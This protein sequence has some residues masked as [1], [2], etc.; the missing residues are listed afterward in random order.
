MAQQ[1]YYWNLRSKQIGIQ[2]KVTGVQ[3][4]EAVST[5]CRLPMAA[6]LVVPSYA[7]LR[8]EQKTAAKEMEAISTDGRVLATRTGAQIPLVIDEQRQLRMERNTDRA[9]DT[10]TSCRCTVLLRQVGNVISHC[11]IFKFILLKTTIRSNS[12]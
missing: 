4:R 6:V 10:V 8:I 1:S 11:E 2:T 9:E 7:R 3:K 12:K 5:K